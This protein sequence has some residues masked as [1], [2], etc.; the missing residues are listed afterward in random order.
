MQCPQ[1]NQN[2]TEPKENERN[3]IAQIDER[4]QVTLKS[5]RP[6]T[7]RIPTQQSTSMK[8]HAVDFQG[9]GIESIAK[10]ARMQKNMRE[11]GNHHDVMD[12]D[13]IDG[14]GGIVKTIDEITEEIANAKG[15]QSVVEMIR[16]RERID[17]YLRGAC[18]RQDQEK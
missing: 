11:E 8:K 6:R 3:I 2:D 1:T 5:Q 9:E 4:S 10:I 16:M 7:R 12:Q 15:N 18:D 14:R 17:E 13:C